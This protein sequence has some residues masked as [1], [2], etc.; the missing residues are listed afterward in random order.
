MDLKNPDQEFLKKSS[1]FLLALIGF[2]TTIKLALIYYD[3]NFNKYAMPSFC[4]INEFVDCDGVAKTIHSQFLGVPLAYWGM[5]L[6]LFIFFLLIVDKLKK[7]KFLGFLEVFKNPMAYIAALGL[8]SFAI[9]MLLAGVSLFEIKK[10]CVLC[11]LTYFINLAIAGV[12][13]D[14]S[15]GILDVFKVSIKDF[16]DALKVKKY[17]ITFI[18]LVCLGIAALADTRLTYRFTPQVKLYNSLLKYAE[19][20]ENPYK[21]EG[22]LLGD[23]NAKTIVYIYTDYRCPMCR[24]YNIMTHKTVKELSGFK[25]IHKNF[26]LDMDCNKYVAVSVHEGACM[27]AKYA[28]A[29]ENQEHFWD[30]NSALFDKKPQTEEDVLKLAKSM[31]LDTEKLE[32]DANSPEIAKRIS[33]EIDDAMNLKIEGTPA[34]VINGKVYVG[35]KPYDELKKILIKAGAVG[36]R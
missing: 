4:S 3:A 33:Q 32:K 23:K 5:F 24:I 12:A 16:I 21:V 29:S 7:I 17:L 27:L 1:I 31:G 28:I 30:M 34:I 25:I 10:V 36:R 18:I 26:P 8:I 14:F 35:L 9:S 22:N 13:I 19:M 20:K 2:I 11:L 6:Y 15:G